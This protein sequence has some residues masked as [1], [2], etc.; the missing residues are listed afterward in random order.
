MWLSAEERDKHHQA[1]CKWLLHNC[2]P[3]EE[4]NI[5]VVLVVHIRHHILDGKYRQ[6]H[7]GGARVIYKTTYRKN[8][9][10]GIIAATREVCNATCRLGNGLHLILRQMV[11][12][13]VRA[14]RANRNTL[15]FQT[16]TCVV[17]DEGLRAPLEGCLCHPGAIIIVLHAFLTQYFELSIVYIFCLLVEIPRWQ[18]YKHQKANNDVFSIL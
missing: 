9:R 7:P 16:E 3:C 2:N 14:V 1:L 6:P 4:C 13:S 5:G 12:D 15:V 10:H 8:R 17:P 11:R 18:S